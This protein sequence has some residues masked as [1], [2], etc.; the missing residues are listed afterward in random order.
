[1]RR[2]GWRNGRSW[3]QVQAE[4]NRQRGNAKQTMTRLITV[5]TGIVLMPCGGWT[6]TISPLEKYRQLE[7]PPRDENFAKGWQERVALEYEIINSTDLKPLRIALKDAD[8]FIRAIAARAL[9]ILGDKDAADALAELVR[10]DPE[11][12][13]RI[14]AVESLGYL[15]MKPEVIELAHKDRDNAVTWVAKLAADQCKSDTYYARQLREEYAKGI[16]H[17]V[18]G[19]AK[20]GRPAPDF[21]ALTRDGKPFRLSTTL[22]KKPIAIYFAAYD[23]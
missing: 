8:P 1:M 18:M 13:V 21:A 23:G 7:Y 14:R 19:S 20:V 12:F 22:G 4:P 3:R 16:T 6:Q 17:E 11:Y 15:K 9:G 10:A 2:N 5:L